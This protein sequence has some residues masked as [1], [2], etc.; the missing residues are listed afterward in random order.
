VKIWNSFGTEKCSEVFMRKE[1]ICKKIPNLFSS[2]K[3]K[4]RKIVP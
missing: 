1:E 2:K 3:K 4:K